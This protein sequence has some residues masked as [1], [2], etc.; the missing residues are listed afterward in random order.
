MRTEQLFRTLPA[1]P[2]ATVAQITLELDGQPVAVPAGISVA[3]ALLLAG[4]EAFHPSAVSQRPRAP[5]CMMGVCFE[6]L[7]EIDGQPNQQSCLVTVQEG[8]VVKSMR[9]PGFAGLAQQEVL[10]G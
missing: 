8:M 7:V 4:L 6:C 5:Y 9:M 1:A 10:H 2:G 3:A